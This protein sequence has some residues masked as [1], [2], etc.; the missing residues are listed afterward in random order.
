MQWA[1]T[2]V[3]ESVLMRYLHKL[4]IQV[5][6]RADIF[7]SNYQTSINMIKS[8]SVLCSHFKNKLTRNGQWLLKKD[9]D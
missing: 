8:F 7:K 9:E 6:L 1:D 4:N 3:G 2:L 5:P